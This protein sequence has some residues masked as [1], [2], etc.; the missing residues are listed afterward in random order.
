VFPCRT[1]WGFQNRS[2]D[3]CHIFRSCCGPRSARRCLFQC[4]TCLSKVWYPTVNRFLIRNSITLTRREA[5]A[6]CTLCC[7]RWPAI[8]Y[9]LLNNK[10]SMFS[11]PHLGVHW[12]RHVHRCSTTRSPPEAVPLPNRGVLYARPC[13]FLPFVLY[14]CVSWSLTLREE[15]WLRV[16][17]NRVLR[18]IFGSKRGKVTG[19]WR[20]L[21]N[22]ELNDLYSSPNIVRVFKL[23]RK[24]WAVHVAHMGERRGIYKVCPKNKCTDF[25]VYELVT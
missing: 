16:F 5:D 1:P 20:K 21:H 9:K 19:E 15:S 7:Y 3:N 11:R 4:R 17:E 23:R 10:G 13:T 8:F 22:E 12:K 18:K 2:P 6:K 24:R 14:G 25:P